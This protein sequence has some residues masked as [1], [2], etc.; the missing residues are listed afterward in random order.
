MSWPELL[1]GLLRGED[2]TAE[3]ASWAMQQILR[4]EATPAQFAA[5]VVALRCKG[6]TVAEIAGM[7]DAML[8]FATP[9]E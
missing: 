7:A 6:E 5:F 3:T 8:E 9:I 4:G 2:Q 1:T